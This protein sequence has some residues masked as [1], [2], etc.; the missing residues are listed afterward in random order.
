MGVQIVN[1]RIYAFHRHLH[2]ANRTFTGRGNHICAI[3]S[4]AVA[5]DFSIDVRAARQSM[6]QLFNHNHTAAASNN[7]TITV[8]IISTGSFIRRFVIFGGQRAHRVELTRHLPAQLF[9]A[10]GKHDIL[11]A[12]LDLFH[13]ITDAVRRRCAGGADGV[14]HTVNFERCCKASGDRGCHRLGHH[15]RTY[16]FQAARAAHGISAKN[17]RL[18]RTARTG[19][20]AHARVLLID[21]IFQACIFNRLLHGEIGIDRGI[22]HET[23]HFTVDQ[24]GCIQFN[25]APYVAAHSRIFKLFR[26]SDPGA[27]FTQRCQDFLLVITNTGNDAQASNHC[28]FH[29]IPL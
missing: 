25:V 19:N 11:F 5:N 6:F 7:E 2:A 9:A 14:V 13:S 12:Q 20:Q 4:C 27:S 18:R 10:T 8:G 21:L 17:L 3:G 24:T 28:T 23:N 26:E 22:V 16:S 15:I 1:R 29:S